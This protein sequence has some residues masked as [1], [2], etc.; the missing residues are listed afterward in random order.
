MAIQLKAPTLYKVQ[1]LTPGGKEYKSWA[2]FGG[3]ETLI[4]RPEGDWTPLVKGETIVN[5]LDKDD[6]YK[7]KPIEEAPWHTN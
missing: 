7:W 5:F 2:S 4:H 6:G 3:E 1:C